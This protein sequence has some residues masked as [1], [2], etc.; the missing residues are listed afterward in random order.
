MIAV[1]SVVIVVVVVVVVVVALVA[2]RFP[3]SLKN[4]ERSTAV[5]VQEF[6]RD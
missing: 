3:S 4:L 6:E 2:L 5:A 1:S